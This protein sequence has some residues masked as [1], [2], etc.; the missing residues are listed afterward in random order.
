MLNPHE[1]DLKP[2]EYE[3]FERHSDDCECDFH[4]G[5]FEEEETTPSEAEINRRFAYFTSQKKGA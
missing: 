4:A 2:A 3:E 1:H 5:N